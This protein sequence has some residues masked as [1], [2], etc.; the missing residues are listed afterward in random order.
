MSLNGTLDFQ[1]K[2]VVKNE[3]ESDWL[4]K[5]KKNDFTINISNEDNDQALTFRTNGDKYKQ[6]I[7]VLRERV[8]E[9]NN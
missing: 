9:A 7:K 3:T 1:T 6:E 2:L 4:D 5:T 8:S